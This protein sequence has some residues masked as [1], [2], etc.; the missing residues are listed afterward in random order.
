MP[1]D[2]ER[3]QKVQDEREVM[4]FHVSAPCAKLS[5][6]QLMSPWAADVAV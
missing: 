2:M 5:Q 6:E 4:Q 3:K 1:E